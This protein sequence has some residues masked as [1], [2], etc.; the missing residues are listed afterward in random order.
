MFSLETK[1]WESVATGLL[2]SLSKKDA[3]KPEAVSTPD[4][5]EAETPVELVAVLA[6]DR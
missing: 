3:T 1:Q 6:E 5:A 4:N 2:S